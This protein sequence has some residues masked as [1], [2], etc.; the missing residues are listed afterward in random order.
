M[1]A[2]SE[3]HLSPLI[4]RDCNAFARQIPGGL[5]GRSWDRQ[6][7][8]PLADLSLMYSLTMSLTQTNF[9]SSVEEYKQRLMSWVLFFCEAWPRI[10]GFRVWTRLS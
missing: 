8:E 7:C 3:A 9:L 10:P 5:G 6:H 2:V 1:L 4:A